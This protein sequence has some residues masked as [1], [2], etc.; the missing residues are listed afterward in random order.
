[1]TY[2]PS[3]ARIRDFEVE[4]P[5]QQGRTASTAALLAHNGQ[6][7]CKRLLQALFR[8]SYL[9]YHIIYKTHG[10]KFSMNMDS[11]L[12]GVKRCEDESNTVRN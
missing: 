3:F 1:M 6:T 8:N 10:W 12:S 11:V 9:V 5:S 2:F 7:Y 4:K